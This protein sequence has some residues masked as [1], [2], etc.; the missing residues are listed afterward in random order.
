MKAGI[1]LKFRN[2]PAF[3]KPFQQVYEE[4][5]E[6][7]RAADALGV[8][9]LVVPE[10][11]S[12]DIGYNPTPFV[13]LAALARETKRIGLSPQPLLLPLYNPVWVAEQLAVL[14]VISGGRAMLGLGLGGREEDFRSYGVPRK[15][16]G[17]RM[18]EGVQIL[19]GALREPNFSYTGRFF[20]VSGVMPPGRF[21]SLTPSSS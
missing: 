9:Y 17:V 1:S 12:F 18:E 19:L 8:D 2:S 13:T 21:N 4:H 11:H 20:Q 3:P 7:A 14:D 10:H 5:F 16:R 15:E 6:Y